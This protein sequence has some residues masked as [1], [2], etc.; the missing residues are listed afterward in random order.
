[1]YYT[2][3]IVFF[4]FQW[5]FNSSLPWHSKTYSLCYIMPDSDWKCGWA[6]SS[7]VA[8]LSSSVSC[9]FVMQAAFSIPFLCV[10][11]LSCLL[12]YITLQLWGILLSFRDTPRLTYISALQ[13]FRWNSFFYLCKLCSKYATNTSELIHFVLKISTKVLFRS[14]MVL[15][16]SMIQLPTTIISQLYDNAYFTNF[17]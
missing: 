10:H 8:H 2:N 16:C 6:H 13:S 1:M 14:K 11:F 12:L 9:H 4:S 7:H 15:S 3:Y 17:L 5:I